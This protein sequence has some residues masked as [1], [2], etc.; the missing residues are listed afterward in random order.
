VGIVGHL[1][2]SSPP[3]SA[4]SFTEREYNAAFEACR[5]RLI[6]VAPDDFPLLASLREDD[7]KSLKQQAFRKR[8]SIE[9]VREHFHS[10]DDLALAVVTALRNW[11]RESTPA[12]SE[13][14]AVAPVEAPEKTLVR[15]N[16]QS[17]FATR[18]E[19]PADFRAP[20]YIRLIAAP[21]LARV[22]RLDQ[23]AQEHFEQIVES[24]FPETRGFGTVIRRG[25]FYQIQSRAQSRSSSHRVWCLWNSGAAGYTANL[26]QPDG[27]P[28]GDLVLHYIFFWRLTELVLGPSGE[29]VLDAQ[30][31]CP[32]ARFTPHFPDPH[33]NRSDYDRVSGIRFD[34]RHAYVREQIQNTKEFRLPVEDVPQ[35][36][37]DLIYFQVQETSAARINFENWVEAIANLF[38]QSSFAAWGKLR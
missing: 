35:E 28:I 13:P 25:E 17:F 11:E 36:L 30:L 14:A 7:P 6:F 38:R 26:D 24:A 16:T 1:Y 22:L 32:S 33:G 27:L 8:V 9:R 4:E 20:D 21:R 12:Q 15:L 5:P 10:P 37:A 29:I 18:G 31:V 23:A 34:E 2:G 19:P 3:G